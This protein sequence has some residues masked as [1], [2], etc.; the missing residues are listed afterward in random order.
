[1]LRSKTYNSYI[2]DMTCRYMSFIF[3]YHV[4]VSLE[5]YIL[6]TP[7]KTALK[8]NATKARSKC[9]IVKGLLGPGAGSKK[10]AKVA[11]AAGP[12]WQLLR[13]SISRD[14]ERSIAK[15]CCSFL[16]NILENHGKP[17]GPPNS[18]I[19]MNSH[20]KKI[21]TSQVSQLRVDTSLVQHLK[22]LGSPDW[23]YPPAA[24]LP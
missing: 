21:I 12:S 23:L 19:L 24:I 15:C 11:A 7:P 10:W 2:I 9:S 6:W 18:W 16:E 5:G 13:S 22:S 3:Y 4:P 1:M 8:F 17:M 20:P 14:S